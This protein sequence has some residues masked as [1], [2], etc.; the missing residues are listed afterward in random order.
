MD[1]HFVR[2]EGETCVIDGADDQLPIGPIDAV[3]ATVGGE[4]YVVE[5]DDEAASSPWLATDDDGTLTV[6]VR[7]AVDELPLPETVYDELGSLDGS[8]TDGVS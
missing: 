5:Y 6:D 3:V 7:S 4:E 1:R 2:I 8:R